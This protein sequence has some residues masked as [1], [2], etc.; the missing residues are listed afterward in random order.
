MHSNSTCTSCACCG[1]W[2][3]VP[4]CQ[5]LMAL[6][7]PFRFLLGPASTSRPTCWT[8][9]LSASRVVVWHG[10]LSF[11]TAYSSVKSL[12]II[13]RTEHNLCLL[14][15]KR[16]R[17]A[18]WGF[19]HAL[20]RRQEMN[21]CEHWCDWAGEGCGCQSSAD[22]ETMMSVVPDRTLLLTL[23]RVKDKDGRRTRC[24]WYSSSDRSC[25]STE[26]T[27]HVVDL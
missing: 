6:S 15:P 11:F 16:N 24:G 1:L 7:T 21:R 13:A 25:V 10:Y 9:Q 23:W 18:Y 4:A 20:S 5:R 2:S 19:P 8:P 14:P 17:V 22:N 3:R 27:V 26:W 12:Y